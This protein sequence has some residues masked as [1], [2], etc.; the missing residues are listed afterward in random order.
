MRMTLM[1]VA[2]ALALTACGNVTESDMAQRIS[3]IDDALGVP[4]TTG[5]PR[6]PSRA[7][8]LGKV[9][10]S[11]GNDASSGNTQS[12]LMGLAADPPP[13]VAPSGVRVA[14]AGMMVMPFEVD[15]EAHSILVPE[16]FC[17][18]FSADRPLPARLVARVT[19][20]SNG[21]FHPD[22]IAMPCAD[23]HTAGARGG[24]TSFIFF[25]RAADDGVP[26]DYF[27]ETLNRRFLPQRFRQLAAS[28]AQGREAQQRAVSAFM[29]TVSFPPD[30]IDADVRSDGTVL[31]FSSLSR[32]SV[33][34]AER[35]FR[36]DAS[37]FRHR[38]YFATVGVTREMLAGEDAQLPVRAD[39]V[40]ASFRP[41]D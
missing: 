3:R 10:D 24:P 7:V 4:P 31:S 33:R 32:F 25:V 12:A 21:R 28:E 2:A 39:R 27:P 17:S 30:I 15:G 20:N 19:G 29:Q 40:R 37:T 8:P 6:L 41:G 26:I 16:G 35:R 22:L 11:G 38:S 1:L 5:Q 13:P 14:P 34:G 23:I 18:L 36:F 9:P